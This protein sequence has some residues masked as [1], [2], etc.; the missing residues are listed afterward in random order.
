MRTL[1]M[2]VTCVKK[3]DTV[4]NNNILMHNYYI[5]NVHA[6]PK[7]SELDVSINIISL[8]TY[9]DYVPKPFQTRRKIMLI[10][11]WNILRSTRLSD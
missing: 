4:Y 6:L 7:G 3:G 2:Y 10:E 9:S 5:T 11:C 1:C 8:D